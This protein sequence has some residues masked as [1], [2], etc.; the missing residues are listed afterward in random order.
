MDITLFFDDETDNKKSQMEE[1][2]IMAI[3]KS[4]I[5]SYMGIIGRLYSEMKID[6]NEHVFLTKYI[7]QGGT[8]INIIKL[9][10]ILNRVHDD[11]MN[12]FCID[13]F[14]KYMSYVKEETNRIIFSEKT[15]E[16]INGVIQDNNM[17]TFTE[18]QTIAINKMVAYMSNENERVF[19][20]YGYAGTGKT[21]TMVELISYLLIHGYIKKIAMTAPTNKAVNIMKSK[22]RVNLR[23]VYEKYT[24]QKCNNDM[25]IDDILDKLYAVGITIDFLTIHRLLNYKNDFNTDGGRIFIKSGKS[26]IESYNLVIIDECSMIPL[27][28]AIHIFEEVCSNSTQKKIIFSGD[29]PQLNPIGEKKSVIFIKSKH[30]LNYTLFSK[31]VQEMEK[32]T[33]SKKI[34]NYLTTKKRYEQL[35]QEIINMNTIMLKQVMRNKIGNVVRLCYNI[36]EWVDNII[37][38]PQLDKFRGNGVFF[39]KCEDNKPKT[40]NSWFKKFITY[41]ETLINENISNIIL[42]WTNEAT[43]L[44]NNEIRKILFGNKYE[45]DTILDRFEIG[46]ILMLGDFYNFDESIIKN[47]ENKNRFYT[48]EQIKV[49]F[50]QTETKMAGE[51]IEQVNKILLKMKH[52]DTIMQKYSTLIKKLN[53]NTTRNYT[54]YNLSVQRLSEAIIKNTIAE[55]YTIYVIHNSSKE[56]HESD[57]SIASSIIKDFREYIMAEYKDVYRIIDKEIIRPLW[58]QWNKLFIDQYANVNYGNSHS[59]HKSQGSSFYNVF[60]D[61]EDILNNNNEEE[62]KR[63]IYTAFTRASNELHILL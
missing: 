54:I 19:G 55:T 46:D 41:Q 52:S 51:F 47:Q 20:L 25:N 10:N 38:A 34:D 8:I 28:I 5:T 39:Y 4:K 30:Q 49:M 11:E 58:R 27:Q 44:Y 32:N 7:Q 16:I 26:L 59:V 35:T 33:V 57:K 23:T 2:V 22:M 14:S 60:V 63:C 6:D 15:Q 9:I 13:T 61:T 48:S 21:T 53:K 31:T 50:K 3:S 43:N 42:T 29:Q 45:A 36:R 40:A 1:K 17:I 12:K 56:T 37:K 24:G 18:D 62:A